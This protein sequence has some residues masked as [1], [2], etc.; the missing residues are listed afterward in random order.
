MPSI[1]IADLRQIAVLWM[2]DTNLPTDEFGTQRISSP[3]EIKVRW[4]SGKGEGTARKVTAF[5]AQEITEGSV[6]WLGYL[7]NLPAP[8]DKPKNLMQVT[9]YKE[10]PDVGNKLPR[11]FVE[12][13]L[14]GTQLPPTV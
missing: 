9:T 6:M 8:P 7:A 5:V 11:R 3:V 4:E 14:L 12:L 10:I 13:V 1:E 2:A